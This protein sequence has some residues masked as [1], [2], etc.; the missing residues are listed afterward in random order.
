MQY[1]NMTT[2]ELVRQAEFDN[3]ELALAIAGDTIDETDETIESLVGDVAQHI[4]DQVNEKLQDYVNS[5]YLNPE[6]DYHDFLFEMGNHFEGNGEYIRLALNDLVENG[7]IDDDTHQAITDRVRDLCDNL[8]TQL[9]QV[10][11]VVITHNYAAP[12]GLYLCGQS[13]GEIEEETENLIDI[14]N[15][16][17]EYDTYQDELTDQVLKMIDAGYVPVDRPRY[18]YFD[19][20]DTSASLVLDREKFIEVINETLEQ[21]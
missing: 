11:D 12:N 15:I 21:E 6:S 19:L 18:I 9:D 14:P 16:F 7:D 1:H 5:Y 4:A 10:C 8:S 13:L 20:S 17:I 3:N 2:D